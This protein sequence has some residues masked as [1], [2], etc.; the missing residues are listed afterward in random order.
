MLSISSS[1]ART[2]SILLL[3]IKAGAFL[4]ILTPLVV[5]GS[6]LFPYV[7][8][9]AVYVRVLIE[10]MF[11]C[12]VLLAVWN[13]E[14]RP[15]RSWILWLFGAYLCVSLLAAVAG[16][17]FQ[18]SFWGDYRRMGG[19]FDLAHWVAFAVVLVGG[20]KNNAN[21]RW[22]L[23]AQLGVSLLVALLG[24]AQYYGVHVL[25]TL[26]GYLSSAG[27]VDIT[28]GNATYVGAYMVVN[29]LLALAFL[30]HSLQTPPAQPQPAGRLGRQERRRREA[31]VQARTPSLPWQFFWIVTAILDLWVLTLSGTRGAVV[32][33]VAGLLFAGAGY[34][35]YGGRPRLK[36]A[37]GVLMAV[38]VTAMLAA[39]LVR[40]SA[41]MR[42]LAKVNITVQRFRTA[43]GSGLEDSSIKIR[44]TTARTGLRAFASAPVLGWGPEN[45]AAAFDSYVQ[46]R[47]FPLEAQMADQAH[48]K[49]VEELTTRG[50]LGFLVYALFI[51]WIVWVAARTVRAGTEERYFALFVGAALVAYVIQ[52]VFL[53]DTPGTF[54]PF[55]ILASW[56]ALRENRTRTESTR[57]GTAAEM[58]RPSRSEGVGKGRRSVND[59]EA[60]PWL[61]PVVSVFALMVLA[62][63]LYFFNYR[64][65]RAAQLFPVE[66]VNAVTF[67]RD[68]QQSFKT[69]PPTANLGRQ[70]LFDTL[71]RNWDRLPA[72][73]RSGLLEAVSGE[74]EAAF[75]GEPHNARM[76]ISLA[77]LY[78]LASASDSQ[79][80]SVAQ[81][82]VE[83]VQ[84]LAPG[85]LD[86]M[87]LAVEQEVAA[88]K[89]AEA[90][91]MVYKYMGADPVMQQSLGALMN[92]VQSLLGAQIGL[93]EYLCR[94]AGKSN[95]TLEERSKI[96]C[97]QKPTP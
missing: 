51:G 73:T 2:E 37:V 84:Q 26:S 43:F 93:D 87:E 76:H 15:P 53:F 40:D 20:F 69:F 18:R 50:L 17:S 48:N 33:L 60:S 52:D 61:L 10:V 63:S 31:R 21:W 54:F 13:P 1:I 67:V 25:D 91:T 32:G 27:R 22:L 55:V 90:L 80:L 12:W 70:V 8:G 68:S 75:R 46:A 71:L 47:E 92:R 88:K 24:L 89:Y 56:L 58:G 79:Y 74:G 95:L 65:Y 5:T 39:P 42:E 59:L 78:Q 66:G 45:F 19:V 3:V 14:Y 4:V 36:L 28:F 96:Q 30:A 11:A 35:L 49:P 38:L 29:V 9:K 86:T 83:V 41:V 97:E 23:N 94:W 82:H 81:S 57:S 6:T 72:D 44:L 77:R 7:V 16:V 64:L 85:L 62:T 34:L